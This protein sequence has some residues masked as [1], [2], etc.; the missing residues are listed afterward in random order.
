MLEALGDADTLLRLVVLQQGSHDAGQ[1]EGTAVQGV[2]DLRLLCL[3]VAIAALQ[4]VGLIGVE[5]A[6]RA[7][8]Q[9]TLLSLA[10]D[11]EVVADGR[12]ERLVAATEA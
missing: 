8:L 11:L 1:G 7:D 6:Y 12:G 4:T 10:V 5:V 3:A 9:P 2:A